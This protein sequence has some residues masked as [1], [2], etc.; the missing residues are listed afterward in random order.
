MALDMLPSQA[1]SVACECTFSGTKQVATDRWAGLSPLLFEELTM[2]QSAWGS[3]LYDAAAW[4]ETQ[5]EEVNVLD[6]EEMLVEDVDS[7]EWAK[8]LYFYGY[9]LVI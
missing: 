5:F 8:N 4:N 6:F 7:S 9:E 1:S 3:G 2:M